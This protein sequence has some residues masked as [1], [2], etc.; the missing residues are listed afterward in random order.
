VGESGCGTHRQ[1]PDRAKRSARC[2]RSLTG[3]RN[4]Q[5]TGTDFGRTWWSFGNH[6]RV[7]H[8][9]RVNP[10]DVSPRVRPP[11]VPARADASSLA[12]ILCPNEIRP[13][14]RTC[15]ASRPRSRFRP[16]RLGTSVHQVPKHLRRDDANG[17]QSAEVSTEHSTTDVS[18]PTPLLT[19]YSELLR[20]RPSR[21]RD[22]RPSPDAFRRGF[23][24]GL[25]F[26]VASFGR[27]PSQL[28]SAV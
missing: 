27:P 2:S 3:T 17:L 24:V 18:Q 6:T 21:A 12:V 15:V 23:G 11:S 1:S 28:A 13:V 7:R 19:Q 4:R 5:W 26:E 20:Y 16:E 10:V 22:W 8:L 14:S 25:V 9:L